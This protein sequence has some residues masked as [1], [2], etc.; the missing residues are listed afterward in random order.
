[1]NSPYADII[2]LPH[3]VTIVLL[4]HGLIHGIRGIAGGVRPGKD[5][6]PQFRRYGKILVAVDHAAYRGWRYAKF[7]CYAL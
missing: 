4:P 6:F 7:L 1:M 2:H 3:H 5:F